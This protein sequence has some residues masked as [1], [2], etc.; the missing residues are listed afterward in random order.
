[1][2]L[3][4]IGAEVQP[5]GN[6][7]AG[8]LDQFAGESEAVISIFAAIGLDIESALLLGGYLET[9]SPQT[10]QQQVAACLKL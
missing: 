5:W 7:H 10:R 3:G 9:E 2:A 4:C 8:L 1:M 6:R